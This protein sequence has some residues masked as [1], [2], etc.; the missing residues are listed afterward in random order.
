M[1]EDNSSYEPKMIRLMV[2]DEGECGKEEKPSGRISTSS[3]RT[4]G[5]FRRHLFELGGLDA[6]RV[7]VREISSPRRSAEVARVFDFVP[8]TAFDLRTG[9]DLST[10]ARLGE[11]WRTLHVK[12]RDVVIGSTV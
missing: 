5:I 1:K 2:R 6:N 7:D 3:T 4:L 8:G 12:V 10:A 9:W 11:C